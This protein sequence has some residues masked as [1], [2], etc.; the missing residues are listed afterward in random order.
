MFFGGPFYNIRLLILFKQVHHI[1]W[2]TFFSQLVGHKL[3]IRRNVLE[4]LAVALAEVIHGEAPIDIGQETVARTLAVAGEKPLTLF[5]LRGEAIGFLTRKLLMLRAVDEFQNRV[6]AQVSE[7][8]LWENEVVAVIDGAVGLDDGAVGAACAHGANAGHLAHPVGERG[9]E[10]LHEERADV[11]SHPEV[12][13][14]TEKASPLLGLHGIGHQFA[15]AV[16]ARKHRKPI[17]LHPSTVI[18]Q[19]SLHHGRELQELAADFAEKLV[20]LA[21]FHDVCTIH[22]GQG[23][24][25]HPVFVEQADASHHVVEG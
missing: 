14:L 5:A 3:H 4:E 8:I 18:L 7:P 15:A 1:R 25:F 13:H 11:T 24:P 6:V 16:E 20:K 9:V 23:I 2:R 10:E 19:T 22:R 17:S 12:E 21:G